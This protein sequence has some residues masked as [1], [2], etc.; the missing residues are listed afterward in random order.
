M[1]FEMLHNDN[2]FGCFKNV[3][4]KQQ[5]TFRSTY[6]FRDLSVTLLPANNT[7]PMQIE[8]CIS[9]CYI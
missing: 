1:Q 5:N 9:L 2:V 4:N 3:S 6:V 8:N 7:K